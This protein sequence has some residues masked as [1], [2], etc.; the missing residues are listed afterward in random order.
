MNSPICRILIDATPNTG[1]WNMAVDEALLETAVARGTGCVRIYQWSTATLS[2]G[3]FQSPKTDEIAAPYRNL[4]RVRR[5]SG[6][7]AILHHHELTYACIVPADH[8]WASDPVELYDLVH[9][10]IISVLADF[11]IDPELR[12]RT[13]SGRDDEFLCFS[14]AN[15]HDVVLAGHKILGSAQRRRKGA[16]LQHGSLVLLRSEYAP[17]FPGL[18]DLAGQAASPEELREALAPALAHA[19]FGGGDAGELTQEETLAASRLERDRQL[20]EL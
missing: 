18:F 19:V 4:P 7:G 20:S 14:R 15:P 17:Q 12:G 10:R 11:G 5:L 2:L 3:Y 6:G 8:G 13:D 1:A 16:V 9:T